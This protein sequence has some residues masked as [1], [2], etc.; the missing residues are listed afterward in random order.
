MTSRI[1]TKIGDIFEVPLDDQSKKYLQYI[2]NDRTQLNS[3]VI[4]AFKPKY[5]INA[6]P[7]V[8]EI[9]ADAVDFYAH[10]VLKPG[11]IRKIW[12]KV[13]N[14]RD[15]GDLDVLFRGTNDI[16]DPQIKISKNWHVWEIDGPSRRVGKLAGRNQKAEIGS[17]MPADQ[18]VHRMRTGEYSF[19]YPSY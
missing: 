10:S 11:I 3:S 7:A 19:V 6:L 1:V 18:I 8:N 2:A 5:T 17:V 12:K 9:T 16:L 13:G 14:S 4:R 15:I